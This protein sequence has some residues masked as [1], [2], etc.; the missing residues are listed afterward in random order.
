MGVPTWAANVFRMPVLDAD[1]EV[2]LAPS[3]FEV[4]SFTAR[5]GST[6]LRA[7]YAKRDGR[8]D[9]AVLMDLGWMDLGYDLAE[10]AS[11]LVLV[12]PERW[13][14]RKTV[15]MHDAAAAAKLKTETSEQLVRYAAMTP[16]LRRDEARALAAQC[17]LEMRSC[18]GAS[19]ENLLRAAVKPDERAALSGL[20]YAPA[21]VAAA[22]GG[23]DGTTLDPRVVGAVAEALKIG[24]LAALDDIP[25]IL[26]VA[27]MRD[28]EKARGKVIAVTGHASAVRRD[29]AYSIGTLTSDAEPVYFVTPFAVIDVPTPV[30]TFRGVFV[31]LYAPIN[32]SQNP[33]TSL[34]LV[35]AFSPQ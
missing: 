35:G 27:A 10:G 31:Q 4:R 29:G 16:T 34:V 22:K 18:D 32:Q 14:G 24:G 11:G 21:L 17:T 23:R 6:S 30:V 2:R 26:P 8:D 1:A 33:P 7:E 12:G 13:F 25:T 19:I 28:S 3:S 9:G 15:A 20:A 5:G